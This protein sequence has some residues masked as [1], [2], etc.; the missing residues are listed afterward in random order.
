[1]A[2]VQQLVDLLKGINDGSI[3][4]TV[5]IEDDRSYVVCDAVNVIACELLITDGGSVNYE[6]T[7][8]LEENGFHVFPVERDSFGWLVGGIRT[9]K[10]VT[11][12]G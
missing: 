2:T 1:M 4:F 11:T 10:G 7:R 8:V 6:N 3:P 9:T 5:E 12:F